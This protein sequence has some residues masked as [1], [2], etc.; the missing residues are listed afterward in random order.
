MKKFVKDNFRLI[1]AC[2]IALIIF[3]VLLLAD[4]QRGSFGSTFA[5]VIPIIVIISLIITD[6]WRNPEIY[7]E[8]HKTKKAL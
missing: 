7:Q 6:R 3:I 2:V 4:M 8:K 5:F 1:V